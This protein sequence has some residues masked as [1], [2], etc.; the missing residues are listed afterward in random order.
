[1]LNSEVFFF[2]LANDKYI[3]TYVRT[4]N[5][6]YVRSQSD[7]HTW[8]HR[9]ML[10][11]SVSPRVR[12]TFNA[13][14]SLIKCQRERVLPQTPCRVVRFGIRLTDNRHKTPFRLSASF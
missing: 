14:S 1:M 9:L 2:T 13:K 12:K 11:D 7:F 3:H 10:S 8:K 5:Y 4:H 6:A